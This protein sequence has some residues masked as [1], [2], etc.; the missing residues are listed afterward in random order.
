MKNVLF[1]FGLLMV[2]ACHSSKDLVTIKG[3][4]GRDGHSLVSMISEA[5]QCECS[6]GGS[7]MDVYVDL[8]D[9]LSASEG[10]KYQGSLV[11]CSGRNGTDGSNG[12]DGEDGA[13]GADGSDGADGQD[14]AD[15]INGEDGADGENGVAGQQ[16]IPGEQGPQGLVGPQG[17]PGT[18][19]LPGP[20]GPPGAP[21]AP[22]LPGAPGS[23]G[24]TATITEYS[25]PNCTMITGTTTYIKIGNQNASLYSTSNCASNSK[26][27]EVSQGES[28]WA[29][30]RSLAVWTS[31]LVRVITFN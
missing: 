7:R 31:N 24:M 15:G 14:G 12:M 21:G 22:G 28:Y 4:P 19:G 20:Q 2:T 29:A 13:N 10:D 26:F 30:S 18:Q 8:D 25:S 6:A 23:S 11:A 17:P 1:W 27:A 3:L 9:S 16:G 5:T